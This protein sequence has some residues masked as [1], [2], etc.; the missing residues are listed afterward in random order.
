MLIHEMWSRLCGR[1]P[2]RSARVCVCV[3]LPNPGGKWP[4]EGFCW[5]TWCPQEPPEPR[6]C[7]THPAQAALAMPEPAHA[8]TLASERAALCHSP[9]SAELRGR[10]PRP[11]LRADL[12][13]ATPSSVGAIHPDP[14]LRVRSHP[15]PPGCV[16]PHL[17][18]AASPA[19]RDTGALLALL[20]PIPC[21]LRLQ[22]FLGCARSSRSAPEVRAPIQ[23]GQGV[24]GTPVCSLIRCS[25]TR[26]QRCL[27]PL[28]LA[29]HTC[30]QVRSSLRAGRGG[31]VASPRSAM[32]GEQRA[33]DARTQV[34]A[35]L[36]M[37]RFVF[38]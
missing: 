20:A 31:A 7:A 18:R 21:L 30:G 11:C 6:S 9:G 16:T 28:A 2:P 5:G 19:L 25:P 27:L 4:N 23:P 26:E 37:P 13:H 36:W 32:H 15:C 22:L 8:A 17:Q 38:P 14:S 24:R 3:P 1:S 34:L 33:P 12:W 35:G 10:C 29:P